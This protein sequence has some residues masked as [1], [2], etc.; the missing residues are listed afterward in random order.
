MKETQLTEKWHFL[1]IWC[2]IKFW[3]IMVKLKYTE[4][5][6][7]IKSK[8]I[9]KAYQNKGEQLTY[10]FY[11]DEFT[12]KREHSLIVISYTGIIR[13][14]EDKERFFLFDSP[15]TSYILPKRDFDKNLIA[16]FRD[17]ITV[18]TGLPME[19]K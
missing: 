7:R 2:F 18:S 12:L 8:S 11:E 13:L 17:F 5:Y 6:T 3:S 14:Y 1:I 10:C 19:H 9:W 16:T 15:K 4:H